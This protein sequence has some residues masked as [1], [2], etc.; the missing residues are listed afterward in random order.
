MT[1]LMCF[2]HLWQASVEAMDAHCSSL[3][4]SAPRPAAQ[5]RLVFERC[6]DYLAAHYTSV[7]GPGAVARACRVG[8]EYLSRLF[9]E[10]TAQTP[11]QFR[12]RLL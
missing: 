8:P 3:S 12:G 1:L 2:H 4:I 6:R 7:R 9:R 11:S 10:H 5:R